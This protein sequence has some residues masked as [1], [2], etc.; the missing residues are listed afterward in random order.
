MIAIDCGSVDIDQIHETSDLFLNDSKFRESH[1]LVLAVPTD[2]SF[3]DSPSF[4]WVQS[5]KQ[6]AFENN[7]DGKVSWLL[8]EQAD[9]E[10]TALKSLVEQQKGQWHAGSCR[11]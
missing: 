8:I 2:R 5:I 7:L 10:L 1:N 3:A 4:D 6:R 11:K 9:C